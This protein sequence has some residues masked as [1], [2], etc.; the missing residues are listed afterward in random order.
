MKLLFRLFLFLLI[1]PSYAQHSISI[2]SWNICD[3]GKTK[4]EEI[5]QLA[6]I[7]KDFDIVL[8]QEVVAIDLGGAK[9]VAR[10]ADQLNRMGNKWDYRISNPTKSPPYKTERYAVLWKPNK[11]KIIN[12]PFLDKTIAQAVF[13]EPFLARFEV[14]GQTILVANY[15]A[16]RFD[17]HP[18]EEIAYFYDYKTRF[19]NDKIIIAGD[20]NCPADDP[21][22]RY[23][24]NIGFQS[25]LYKQKTTLKYK[26]D[27]RGNYLN[28]PI[29]FILYDTQHFI[30]IE[31]G[32][33]DFV[34]DCNN[35]KYARSFS[36]HL[37]VYAKFRFAKE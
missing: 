36:D 22:F 3:F 15:H 27:K 34:N 8:I 29:D 18:T 4:Y 35:V 1:T 7:V 20:F 26:C 21:I 12:R 10:L 32:A 9:A 23:L 25:N 30:K 2:V 5:P 19:P 6:K 28:H 31:A 17:E 14:K 16:R 37:P 13:R 24:Q 33:I 11:A